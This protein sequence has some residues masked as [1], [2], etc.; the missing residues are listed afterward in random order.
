MAHPGAPA[1]ATV[2][3]L[4]DGTIDVADAIGSATPTYIRTSTAYVY[5]GWAEK[6]QP[7]VKSNAANYQLQGDDSQTARIHGARTHYN[8]VRE[9]G[10][11]AALGVA[12]WNSGT[13]T[14]SG[15]TGTSDGIIFGNGGNETS[16]VSPLSAYHVTLQGAGADVGKDVRLEV[17]SG[18]GDIVYMEVRLTGSPATYG[19]VAGHGITGL[20]FSVLG[21]ALNSADTCICTLPT[22]YPAQHF[23]SA[24]T[25]SNWDVPVHNQQVNSKPAWFED[26]TG[27]LTVASYWQTPA[28]YIDNTDSNIITVP[29]PGP[30]PGIAS[31]SLYG[32]VIDYTADQ[33]PLHPTK[34]VDGI[35]V[36]QTFPLA[37]RNTAY[38]V[39]DRV[40][41][42]G[43][44]PYN[45]GAS[46]T[47][48][49]QS[50]VY[51]QCSVA[52]TSHASITINGAWTKTSFT[53]ES[54]TIIDD[55][56]TWVIQGR[57]A[58]H[59]TIGYL[60]EEQRTNEAEDD[61]LDFAAWPIGAAAF[62][63]DTNV[64]G[65]SGDI[66]GQDTSAT[67]MQYAQAATVTIANDNASYTMSSFIV[68]E[69][70]SDAYPELYFR[71]IGGTHQ[72][73][74]CLLNK[75]TGATV[76]EAGL[77]HGVVSVEDWGTHWRFVITLTNNST[78]NVSIEQRVYPGAS[79]DFIASSNAAQGSCTFSH[80]QL[81]QAPYASSPI[82]N[83]GAQ[84]T[85]IA[86]RLQYPSG[87]HGK[88]LARGYMMVTGVTFGVGDSAQ[89]RIISAGN[90]PTIYFA[91]STNTNISTYESG[92]TSL[93]VEGFSRL[94][95]NGQFQARTIAY[96]YSDTDA[97]SALSQHRLNFSGGVS[98]DVDAF[99][100][101]VDAT[102]YIGAEV[103]TGHW[104][105]AISNFFI[106][107]D[108]ITADVVDIMTADVAYDTSASDYVAPVVEA[109]SRGSIS[110]EE[111]AAKIKRRN[112]RLIRQITQDD[113][114]VLALYLAIH[115]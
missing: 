34:T 7:I 69:E 102:L 57:A 82:I 20:R 89:G 112:K 71:L 14:V 12:S 111:S 47:A 40:Y 55:G 65:V 19:L 96:H 10:D 68:K 92:S 54:D 32:R 62:T 63:A 35:Q 84:T 58:R 95:T 61:S 105:G 109:R 2:V 73:S 81:E 48:Y 5:D 106:Y 72:S 87:T 11:W 33:A 21:A 93:G 59:G 50:S 86:D 113:E 45:N 42:D 90:S 4:A 66:R 15:M 94:P 3:P 43:L 9:T 56:V 76:Q 60:A 31:T 37:I 114:E 44:R 18:N 6:F 17:R 104:G 77:A 23:L 38:A 16:P 36:F 64:S 80:Y 24:A 25:D 22:A 103:T 83:D 13:N 115:G 75:E 26:A 28:R 79:T 67:Q 51:L 30:N 49:D 41:P 29:T 85:R 101:M 78:G 1:F 108:D 110:K 99:D 39:G 100:V 107:D 74:L 70:Q 88:N 91:N 98:A 27:P 46:G 52:G 8:L 53:F 97:D